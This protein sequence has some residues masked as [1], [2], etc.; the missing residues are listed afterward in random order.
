M[1]ESCELIFSVA[2]SP[3]SLRNFPP[4]VI[5][6]SCLM[7][8]ETIVSFSKTLVFSTMYLE[9]KEEINYKTVEIIFDSLV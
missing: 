8:E 7:L 9:H 2:P 6:K 1:K 5:C 3:V 4:S